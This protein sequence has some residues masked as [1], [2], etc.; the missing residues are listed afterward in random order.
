MVSVISTGYGTLAALLCLVYSECLL[1][2]AAWSTCKAGCSSLGLLACT[3]WVRGMFAFGMME[4]CT[5]RVGR[6]AA[7]GNCPQRKHLGGN[8]A[9][10][11]RDLALPGPGGLC[12][13]WAPS[14]V[15][16]RTPPHRA[17]SVHVSQSTSSS[18]RATLAPPAGTL[19]L[20]RF[21]AGLGLAYSTCWD[22]SV[23][24][25]ALNGGVAVAND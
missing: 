22:A 10:R 2:A 14:A 16:A 15:P 13:Q 1:D 3:C 19:L 25:A 8:F 24:V 7:A 21:L 4:A 12:V 11:S 6:A 17:T 20:N 23:V 9:S 18:A 5:A